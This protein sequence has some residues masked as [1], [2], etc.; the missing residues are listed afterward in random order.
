MSKQPGSFIVSFRPGVVTGIYSE[1]EG[2]IKEI[3]ERF[4]GFDCKI[5]DPYMKYAELA[6]AGLLVRVEERIAVNR[7]SVSFFYPAQED[8]RCIRKKIINSLLAEMKDSPS[9]Y[10]GGFA[11]TVENNGDHK[12]YKRKREP[13]RQKRKFS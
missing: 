9:L 5:F 11:V 12:L 10:A 1:K 2:A 13:L 6:D 3:C 8:E 4:G 7:Y